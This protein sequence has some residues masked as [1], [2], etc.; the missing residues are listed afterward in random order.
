MEARAE[1]LHSEAAGQIDALIEFA[2]NLESADLHRPC[3]GRERLGDGSVGTLLAHT[4]DNYLRI[5]ACLRGDA[6]STEGGHRPGHHGPGEAA[7][8]GEL[9]D[10]LARARVE[11]GR[12]AELDGD[13]L[14]SIPAAGS[15]RFADGNRTVEQIVGALL[16]HQ[17]HQVEALA[18][19]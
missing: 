8:P 11:L 14:D 13:E 15:F 17:G 18:R 7:N 3:P 6:P 12:I 1:K 9:R 19:S 10:R 16:T 5:C 4:A 2:A